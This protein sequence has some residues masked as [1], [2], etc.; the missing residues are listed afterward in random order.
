MKIMFDMDGTIANLYACA[1][2]LEKLLAS[3]PTPYAEAKPMLDMER[4][5]ILLLRAQSNGYEIGI[6]SWLSK[7]GSPEYNKQVRA[8]KKQWLRKQLPS[9]TFNEIH[10]VK[11]GTPKRKFATS[12]ADILFDDE[13]QNRENWRGV[14][15]KPEEIE[16]VLNNSI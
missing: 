7:N 14:A 13:K 12:D 6:I 9:V 11:Y 3:N 4:L 5:S 1:D 16:T 8:T 15:Y 2:W 10:I